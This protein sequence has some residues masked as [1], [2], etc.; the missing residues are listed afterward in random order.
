MIR[1]FLA[2]AALAAAILAM[3]SVEAAAPQPGQRPLVTFDLGSDPDPSVVQ[4]ALELAGLTESLY[5]EEAQ[6]RSSEPP[7]ASDDR[8]FLST[9]G[10]T[11]RYLGRGNLLEGEANEDASGDASRREARP[12]N[13]RETTS[14]FVAFN[15]KTRHE[16][17]ITSTTTRLAMFAAAAE[18]RGE[19]RE[20]TVDP[21]GRPSAGVGSDADDTEAQ[22]L[23]LLLQPQPD[24]FSGGNDDRTRP[25]GINAPVTQF[26]DRRRVQ[27]GT[28]CSGTLIGPRHVV[29]AGH[30]LYNRTTRA[31]S[32]NFNVRA[33]AN[34]S[35]SFASVFVNSGNIPAGQV[36]WYF[37]PVEWRNASTQNTDPFDIGILVLPGNLG[38]QAGG[39]FGYWTLTDGTLQQQTI[40]KA[41]YPACTATFGGQPRIDVPANDAPL[42]CYPNHVY[43]NT[44]PCQVGNFLNAKGGWNRTLDHSCDGSGGDSGSGLITNFNGQG[45]GVIGVHFFSLCG[46]TANDVAC[47]GALNTLALRAVRITPEYAGWIS[48]FR[49][50][51]P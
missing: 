26:N 16:F 3:P 50:R 28:G 24:G 47:T 22:M 46:K 34:G 4:D 6:S 15:P 37:T 10:F 11:V 45:N 41:G 44:N 32:N 8:K 33:G 21:T 43:A 27:I 31:W 38:N 1:T 5:E 2:P 19:N 29:T 51:F 14:S 42:S 35:S 36:L 12:V 7:S 30:C 48:Y 17:V 9:T 13:E 39:W 49:N 40:N 20:T 25:Y 18:R 23:D